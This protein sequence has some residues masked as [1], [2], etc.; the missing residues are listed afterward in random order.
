MGA[1]TLAKGLIVIA[2]MFLFVGF[3][4]PGEQTGWDT[5]SAS[6]QTFPNFDN[7]FDAH[8][9][10][11]PLSPTTTNNAFTPTG[12]FG[13]SGCANAT[14]W[15]C[16]LTDDG[17]TSYLILKGSGYYFNVNVTTFDNPGQIVAVSMQI[18]CRATAPAPIVNFHMAGLIETVALPSCPVSTR[19]GSI[20]INFQDVQRYAW[21]GLIGCAPSTS[22]CYDIGTDVQN[23]GFTASNPITGGAEI[24]ISYMRLDILIAK[25]TGDET[26]CT[27]ADF[28]GNIGCQVGRFFDTF[29]KAISFLFNGIIYVGQVIAYGV[30]VFVSLMVVIAFFFTVPNA[31]DVV[32]GILA[33]FFIGYIFLIVF[34]IANLIR[35]TGSGLE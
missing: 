20:S 18:V 11:L 9:F 34:A 28:F 14:Y 13:V 25:A 3:L 29:V 26:G 27:G 21:D 23:H 2:I 16:L 19:F 15:S 22:L 4:Y 10:T 1:D 32:R 6:I 35:G 24:D 5:F 17:A 30:G 31:P 7:P 12:H 8:A 33:A